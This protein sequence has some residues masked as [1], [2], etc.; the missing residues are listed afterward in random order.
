MHQYIYI[1]QIMLGKIRTRSEPPIKTNI[2]RQRPCNSRFSGQKYYISLIGERVARWSP[3]LQLP[4]KQ[5][6]TREASPCPNWKKAHLFQQPL[7][8][9]ANTSIASW[10]EFVDEYLDE[11]RVVGGD[12]D[13]A[14]SGL[15]VL[16]VVFVDVLELRLYDEQRVWRKDRIC[17]NSWMSWNTRR[18]QAVCLW[19]AT[20]VTNK[21]WPTRDLSVLKKNQHFS[22]F[23][24]RNNFKYTMHAYEE[25]LG[26]TTKIYNIK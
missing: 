20:K 22:Y 26:G 18:V 25:R 23:T 13:L 21:S 24:F 12:E 4:Q 17:Y 9:I 3:W 14:L 10:L 11:T 7:P 19:K 1:S 2:Y 15:R 5:Q 6:R 8:T 16:L